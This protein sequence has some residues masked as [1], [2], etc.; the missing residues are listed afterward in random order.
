MIIRNMTN[1]NQ[2]LQNSN[3]QL[4]Q[5]ETNLSVPDISFY[6]STNEMGKL[7]IQCIRDCVER[8]VSESNFFPLF[9]SYFIVSCFSANYFP[10]WMNG[11]CKECQPVKTEGGQDET[12]LYTYF[13]DI[14]NLTEIRELGNQIKTNVQKSVAN[15]KRYLNRWKKY[16]SLWK[17]DKVAL[18]EKFF[19][20]NQSVVF[21]DEKMLFYNRTIEEINLAPKVKDIEFIK[22][23]MRN[24]TDGLIMHSKEWI[25]CIGK[26]LN[27]LAKTNLMD[28]KATLEVNFNTDFYIF[29]RLEI[30]INFFFFRNM[31]VT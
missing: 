17:A 18:C 16:R 5:V 8:L 19:S 21:F 10:R 22:L 7:F 26:L 6:P 23:S 30:K 2:S 1:F 24:L 3:E 20:K 12:Y 31:K 13:N 25:K 29:W 4:F 11:T 9:L 15:M 27:E 14:E 28:L